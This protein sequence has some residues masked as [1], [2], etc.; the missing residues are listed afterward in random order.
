MLRNAISS[1]SSSSASSTLRWR[2]SRGVSLITNIYQI[3]AQVCRAPPLVY[4][5]YLVIVRCRELAFLHHGL[6]SSPQ[7]LHLLHHPVVAEGLQAILELCLEVTVDFV[8]LRQDHLQL[9][10]DVRVYDIILISEDL[11]IKH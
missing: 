6:V 4:S 5:L 8:V 3:T 1:H 10:P 11:P 2:Y 7:R 9:S